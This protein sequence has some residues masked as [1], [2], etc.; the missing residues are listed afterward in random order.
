M[1]NIDLLKHALGVG[2]ADTVDS[3]L[4]RTARSAES[5][6]QPSPSVVIFDP[7]LQK[8]E[9]RRQGNSSSGE[10]AST[11]KCEK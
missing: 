1:L 3:V 8:I 6:T 10:T 9:A 4:E 7:A 2:A 5:A 11:T